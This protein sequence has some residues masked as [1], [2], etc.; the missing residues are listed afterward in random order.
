MQI[1]FFCDSF[2]K[3][4]NKKLKRGRRPHDLTIG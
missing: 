4:A 2:T 1:L 3:K